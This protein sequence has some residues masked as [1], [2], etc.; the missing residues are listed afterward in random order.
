MLNNENYFMKM[1]CAKLEV[2]VVGLSASGGYVKP[3]A[4]VR[5]VLH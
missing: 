5:P 4:G 2:L 3:I 1:Q